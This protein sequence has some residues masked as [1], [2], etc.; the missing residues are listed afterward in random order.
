MEPANEGGNRPDKGLQRVIVAVGGAVIVFCL[1][2][3][4]VY[5]KMNDV[6]ANGW[7]YRGPASMTAA[8]AGLFVGG[9]AAFVALI[10]LLQR[11]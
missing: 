9:F 11:R 6:S 7:M 10:L 2:A 5:Y 8:G 4:V 1:V 3:A